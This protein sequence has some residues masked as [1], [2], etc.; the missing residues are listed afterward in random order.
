MT[1]IRISS[2]FGWRTDPIN[3]ERRFHNGLDIALP[4]GTPIY[5]LAPGRVIWRELNGPVNGTAVKIDHGGGV[6]SSYVHLSRLDIE[7]GQMVD[8]SRPIGLSG[9]ARGS[10]GAGRSTGPH[11]HLILKINGKPVDPLPKINWRAYGVKV[12]Q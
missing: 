3:G 4:Q 6:S 10:W 2:P 8:R 12:T 1:T 5:A 11:L 9:G 7:P